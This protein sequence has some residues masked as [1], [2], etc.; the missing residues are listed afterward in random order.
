MSK[1]K[2]EVESK[3]SVSLVGAGRLGTALAV[4]LQLCGYRIEAVVAR[5]LGRARRAAG[6]FAQRPLALSDSQ[7][8]KLPQSHLILITTPDDAITTTAGRLAALQKPQG[9]S[10]MR[11]TVLHTSGALSSAALSP[12]SAAG[13]QVG[14]LHPLVSVSDPVSGLLNLRGAF[15][16]LEGDRLALRVA[17]AVVRDLGGKSFSVNPRRKALYHA[18]AVMASGHMVA[19]FDIAAEM[20]SECGLDRR[21]ARRVLLPLLQS[22]VKN[23]SSSNPARVLTGTFARGDFA[24]VQRHLEA[25]LTAGSRD[26]IG[27]YNLLGLR[28][29]ELARENGTQPAVLKKIAKALKQA[30]RGIG[31]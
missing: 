9:R 10:R 20:L 25:L 16:C 19:L 22:T 27:A 14:S 28:S 4:A 31:R 2:R 15:Y 1:Q 21:S 7:L 24:T 5:R 8:D 30:T 23:L 26:A 11:R 12:L 18:A 3:P 6:L 17:R 29:L 13:F